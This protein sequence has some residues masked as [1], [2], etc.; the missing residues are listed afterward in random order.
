MV[1]AARLIGPSLGGII[2]AAVGEGW[3]F[4]LDGISY[5][6]VIISLLMMRIAARPVVKKAAVNTLHQLREGWDY[7]SHFAPIRALLTLLALVSLI[8]MPY[9]VLMPVFATKILHGNPSTLGWLMASSGVGA[10]SSALFLASRKSV[11]G[12]GKLIPRAVTVFGLGL[13]AFSF[14][15]TLWLSLPLMVLMGGGFMLQMASSNTIVQTI[16]DDD[17]R[18]RVMSFYMMA[19]MGMAPFGSLLA[20]ALANKIGAPHTV[21][22][23]GIGCIG[24]ALWFG[25]QYPA[26]RDVV[27]PMYIEMGIVPAVAAGMQTAAELSVPPED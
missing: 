22:L 19:F 27:R 7:V 5:I 11:A 25:R 24:G 9:T 20:G 17:K 26:L 23:C 2:I 15:R 10:L 14:S 8:G 12:L 1:N 18:G 13:V 16:V 4:L 3:C 21:L 6:A